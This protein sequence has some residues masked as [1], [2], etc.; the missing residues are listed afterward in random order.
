MVWLFHKFYM[1]LFHMLETFY[2]LS[3]FPSITLINCASSYRKISLDRWITCVIS[4]STG[5]NG[6][7]LAHHI[8]W[9]SIVTY[10]F[11]F[12]SR[13]C[14]VERIQGIQSFKKNHWQL[15]FL[16]S[17]RNAKILF[18]SILLDYI[19]ISTIAEAHRFFKWIPLF[20]SLSCLRSFPSIALHIPT[21]HNFTSH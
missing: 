10:H 19:Q 17:H 3:F 13:Q 5:M 16:T 15:L 7:G 9:A 11:L 21:A 4:T 14:F 20:Q 2:L 6:V 8:S 12:F 1:I 18:Q